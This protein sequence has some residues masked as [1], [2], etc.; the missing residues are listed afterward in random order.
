[1]IADGYNEYPELVLPPYDGMEFVES[2]KTGTQNRGGATEVTLR[3]IFNVETGLIEEVIYDYNADTNHNTT[4]E[5][6]YTSSWT[7]AVADS[8]MAWFVGKD[9]ATF[10][11]MSEITAASSA[12][13]T[14]FSGLTLS[15]A[16]TRSQRS[17]LNA[18]IAACKAFE[19]GTAIESD[20]TA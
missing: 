10:A 6:T 3:V 7:S 11:A 19:A 4:G 9:A 8:T 15:T 18:V 14:D 20:W 2:T 17:F 16:A 1:M 13:S 5:S 12:W